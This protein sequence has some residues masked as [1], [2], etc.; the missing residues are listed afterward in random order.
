MKYHL[1]YRLEAHPEGLTKEEVK[2]I[3]GPVGACTAAILLSLLYPEDGS[4]SML[5]VMVDGRTG[6][7]L[8]DAELWKA[9]MML[10]KTLA[11]SDTLSENKKALCQAVFD[12]I[13]TALLS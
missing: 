3:E 10:S 2:K 13:R 12:S 4:Y 1:T 7:R 5:P 11:D 6:D 9:W 8:S